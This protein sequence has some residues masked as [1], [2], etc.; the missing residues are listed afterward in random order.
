MKSNQGLYYNLLPV[1]SL[2]FCFCLFNTDLTLRKTVS[3]AMAG[4]V[5]FIEYSLGLAI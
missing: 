4:K 2:V 1:V 3:T 5:I